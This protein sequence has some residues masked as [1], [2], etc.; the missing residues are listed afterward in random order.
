MPL[1]AVT[2]HEPGGQFSILSLPVDPVAALIQAAAGVVASAPASD[3]RARALEL[4]Q[5]GGDAAA[6][7]ASW[8]MREALRG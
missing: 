4:L 1:R 3:G 7:T 8:V 6:M 5:G 2:L